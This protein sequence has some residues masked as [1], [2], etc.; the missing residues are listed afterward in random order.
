MESQH[1]IWE[2]IWGSGPVVQ[3]VLIFLI[4]LSLWSWAIAVAKFLQFRRVRRQSEE[5]RELFWET[6]SIARVSDSARRLSASPLSAIFKAGYRE[7]SRVVGEGNG[8]S[9]D[10]G[11]R[12]TREGRDSSLE[13]VRKALR[14]AEIEESHRLEQGVPFL[15]TVASAAP[16]I[17]LFGTVWGIMNAF[18]GLSMVKNSTLQ[19]VA[20]GISEALVATAV[21]L[22]AAIPASWAYNFC[23]VSIRRFKEGMSEFSDEFLVLAREIELPRHRADGYERGRGEDELRSDR[24]LGA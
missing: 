10:V 9:V 15:G 12:A 7:L 2:M 4:C 17:G 21:G 13:F 19:A 22:A 20:P 16:F 6:R 1:T 8:S 11:G 3:G 5:F 24:A 18:H 23:A 14:H